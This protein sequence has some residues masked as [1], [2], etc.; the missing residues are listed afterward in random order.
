[1]KMMFF[2]D[3]FGVQVVYRNKYLQQ[4]SYLCVRSILRRV[5]RLCRILYHN[6]SSR[7]TM[8]NP[9]L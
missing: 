4:V 8:N 1:M 9:W 6:T 2:K 5:C 3:F 7:H